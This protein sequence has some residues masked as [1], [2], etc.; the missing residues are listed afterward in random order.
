MDHSLAEEV[1]QGAGDIA[2]R[3]RPVLLQEVISYWVRC[4]GFYIDATLGAGGH[5]EAL[6]RSTPSDYLLLGTDWDP[7][8]VSIAEK[9]LHPFMGRCRIL[10]ENF[11]ALGEI[12]PQKQWRP[13]QGALFDFGISS[14]HLESAQRGFSFQKEGPLDMRL[15]PKQPLTADEII[16]G[17][18]LRELQLLF[19]K[20]GEERGAGKIARAILQARRKSRIRTTRELAQIIAEVLPKRSK[21]HPATRVFLAL[22]IAINRELEN[23]H[24]GISGVKAHLAPGGRILALSFHSLEDRRVK[25][26]FKNWAREGGWRLLTSKPIRPSLSERTQNPRSRSAKLRVIEK[27]I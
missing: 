9:R 12:I 6:L 8:M 7:E 5:S 27:A 18:S 16:N 22:R 1:C 17:W 15:S 13:V 25:Q 21:L 23:I 24:P 2:Y 26:E 10:C 4:S 14:Y 20:Y 3:H 19:S 11:A